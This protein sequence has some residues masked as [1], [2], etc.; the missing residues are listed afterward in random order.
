METEDAQDKQIDKRKV[1][2]LLVSNGIIDKLV[3]FSDKGS[4]E[5]MQA[6]L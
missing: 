1:S 2:P 5:L 6:G 3:S 4:V